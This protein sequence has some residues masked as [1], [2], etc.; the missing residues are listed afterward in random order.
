VKKAYFHILLL[1]FASVSIT[2]NGQCDN[3]I[4]GTLSTNDS[5]RCVGEL[6]RL[7]LS[8]YLGTIEWQAAS[9]S[10]DNWTT[11][12]S[13]TLDMLIVYPTRDTVYRAYLNAEDGCEDDS[14]TVLFIDVLDT[15]FTD[16]V[17][18]SDEPCGNIFMLSAEGSNPGVWSKK[19]G[20][21]ID[22]YNPGNTSPTVEVNVTEYGEYVFAFTNAWGGCAA[23]NIKTFRQNKA[24]ARNDIRYCGGFREPFQIASSLSSPEATGYWTEIGNSYSISDVNDTNPFITPDFEGLFTIQWTEELGDCSHDTVITFGTF[25]QPDAAINSLIPFCDSTGNL[26]AQS[27][28]R[29]TNQYWSTDSSGNKLTFSDSTSLTPSVIVDS[30]DTYKV[31]WT[32]ENDYC[33]DKDSVQVTFFKQPV[34]NAGSFSDVCSDSILLNALPSVDTGYWSFS[35]GPSALTFADSTQPVT[36]VSSNGVYD[37][38]SLLWKE[39]NG[40]CSDSQLISFDFFEQPVANAGTPDSLCDLSVVMKAEPSVNGATG[41]WFQEGGGPGTL[42]LTSLNDPLSTGNASDFG[43]YLMRWV[44][45]NEI[46]NDTD[47]VELS[48]FR[49]PVAY[50]GVDSAVCGR[51]FNLAAVPSLPETEGWWDKFTGPGDPDFEKDSAISGVD[52]PSD[53]V[54][55]FLWT[56]INKGTCKNTDIVQI[57]FKPVPVANVDPGG[58]VCGFSDT[59]GAMPVSDATVWL[60]EDSTGAITFFP[61]R[62]TPNARVTASSPGVYNLTWRVDNGACTTDST[63]SLNF[64]EQPALAIMQDKEQCGDSIQLIASNTVGIGEWSQ[65]SFVGT[66]EFSDRFSG[67]TNARVSMLN[68]QYH[69]QWTVKNGACV[70]SL[71]LSVSFYEI[72]TVAVG[73]DDLIC[74]LTYTLNDIVT[75]Y[76][77]AWQL[78]QGQGE[79]QFLPDAAISI[80]EILVTEPG[81]Y[82]ILRAD[83][84]GICYNSDTLEINFIDQPE[85]SILPIPILFNEFEAPL[86]ADSLLS[87]ESGIWEVIEGAGIII[88]NRQP[89]TEITD[90]S[91]GNNIV[92][93]TVTNGTCDSTAILN[94]EVYDI[95]IPEVITPNG[96]GDN[97]SFVLLGLE[98][99]SNVELT[100]F[101]RWGIEVYYNADYQNEWEGANKSG[102]ELTNDTYFYVVN[103][104]NERIIKGFV[105]I[106]R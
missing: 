92:H 23:V 12:T 84:N 105:V 66:T 88:D 104:Q 22:F 91:L 95:Q 53:G 79:L 74:G 63:I 106:K 78:I 2:L 59:L 28:L 60:V 37:N 86:I 47:Y 97:D 45:E 76:P 80:P 82:T 40:T 5:T 67:N 14:S 19:S 33:T 85:P 13:D 101:N 98:D 69:Y 77:G 24:I 15:L 3:A 61:D 26:S 56:E 16:A 36:W 57:T 49:T 71:P 9:A 31:Y 32:V 6:T 70:D 18:F 96:D 50:A 99:A 93:W 41:T 73:P 51:Q 58:E 89:E 44:E 4:G 8:G 34:A 35:S 39:V 30:Y 29:Y 17:G 62:F 55:E 52:V 65:S 42:N 38:Y 10:M 20:P 27:V 54:Y 81:A 25:V 43:V 90:L 64:F 75:D 46:C 7:E 48:F 94:I 102:A 100:V 103:I 72:P 21:G 11:I 1:V 83:T 68:E 87:G